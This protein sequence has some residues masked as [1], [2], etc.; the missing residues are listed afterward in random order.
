M[1]LNEHSKGG[2]FEMMPTQLWHQQKENTMDSVAQNVGL[3]PGS[4]TDP[5]PVIRV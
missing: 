3:Q 1:L 4:H 5:Y 2:N